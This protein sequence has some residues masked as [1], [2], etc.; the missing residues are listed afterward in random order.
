MTHTCETEHE[1]MTSRFPKR[2]FVILPL[3]C[4]GAWSTYFCFLAGILHDGGAVPFAGGLAFNAQAYGLIAV[5]AWLS[6]YFVARDFEDADP[7]LLF[8]GVAV[9]FIVAFSIGFLVSH[10]YDDG[11]PVFGYGARVLV[12][13]SILNLSMATFIITA[14][15]TYKAPSE[16]AGGDVVP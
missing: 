9:S 14:L 12:T 1:R 13:A 8:A 16:R 11:I 10:F 4:L 5:F 6:A 15:F 2:I 7:M 3:I